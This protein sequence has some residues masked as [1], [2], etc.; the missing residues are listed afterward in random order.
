MKHATFAFSHSNCYDSCDGWLHGSC[1]EI[2]LDQAVQMVRDKGL[3]TM[4]VMPT[5]SSVG[6]GI[7]PIAV[8]ETIRRLVSC[9]C[10]S[11]VLPLLP[12]GQ[13]RVEAVIY[14]TRYI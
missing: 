5:H 3:H 9:L 2:S 6:R 10:C 12:E 11:S 4:D 14:A 1:A 13:V 7:R 8:G